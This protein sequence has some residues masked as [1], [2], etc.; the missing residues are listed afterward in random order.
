MGTSLTQ[1]DIMGCGSSVPTNASAKLFETEQDAAGP[2]TL[3]KIPWAKG[4]FKVG[5]VTIC[6]KAVN[7]EP[8][9]TLDGLCKKIK[10]VCGCSCEYNFETDKITLKGAS[11]IK[12]GAKED[13]SNL[14]KLAQLKANGK[15][16][17][18]SLGK[19][20]KDPDEPVEDMDMTWLW[21]PF[22]D[23]VFSKASAPLATMIDL[24]G[25]ISDA[26]KSAKEALAV[27][28][29]VK[30]LKDGIVAL[31]KDGLT[32]EVDPA[33]MEVT[34]TGSEIIQPKIDAV[35]AFVEA[36]KNI[37]KSIPSLV[38]EL[39]AVVPM[40]QEKLDDS[41]GA[42]A[43]ISESGYTG[44]KALGVLKEAGDNM[45]KLTGA[46]TVANQLL[47]EVKGVGE[48]LKSAA[49]ALK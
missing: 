1:I 4:N 3:N 2:L 47:A 11:E 35:K 17:V 22:F 20:G 8:T 46:I 40:V 30:S 24:Q 42:K 7:I 31:K 16:Q 15:N 6:E 18:C 34:F 45:K 26:R 21:V 38:E 25:Q 33:T 36:C 44:M 28:K 43:A 14:L 9:D 13:T 23:E 49:D 29:G 5:Q 19:V 37:I 41:D 10:D 39:Q 12:L 27:P 48:D 32:M